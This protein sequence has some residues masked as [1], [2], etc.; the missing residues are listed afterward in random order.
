MISF[1]LFGFAASAQQVYT[2]SSSLFKEHS[3]QILLKPTVP[4]LRFSSVN[5]IST[6]SAETNFCPTTGHLPMFCA[7]EKKMWQA[8]KV[9]I[10]IGVK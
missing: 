1:L 7:L 6:G 5:I 10:T 8:T 4:D 2:K 3:Q 9:W